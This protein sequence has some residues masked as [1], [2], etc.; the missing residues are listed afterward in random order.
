MSQ[1]NLNQVMPYFLMP[2]AWKTTQSLAVHAYL[3]LPIPSLV[4][5]Q[6]LLTPL[7]VAA[8]AL[9]AKFLSSLF[10]SAF[11]IFI[12]QSRHAKP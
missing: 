11:I 7:W 9:G 6:K 1:V 4:F 2:K 12:Q 10:Q 3:T 5:M 8:F